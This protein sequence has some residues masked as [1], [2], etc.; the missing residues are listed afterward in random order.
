MGTSFQYEEMMLL[1]IIELNSLL[2]HY[3]MIR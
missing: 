3:K 2:P 1:R